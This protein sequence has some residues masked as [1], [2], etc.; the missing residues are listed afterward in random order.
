MKASQ[1]SHTIRAGQTSFWSLPREL[2]DQIYLE[3]LSDVEPAPD[4]KVCKENRGKWFPIRSN[5][6]G[7][8]TAVKHV[9][10]Q[11]P[12]TWRWS[13]SGEVQALP[14]IA[15]IVDEARETILRSRVHLD[16]CGD[17]HRSEDSAVRKWGR[18]LGEADVNSIQRLYVTWHVEAVFEQLS[19]AMKAQGLRLVCTGAWPDVPGPHFRINLE[20]N[21]QCITIRSRGELSNFNKRAFVT[22]YRWLEEQKPLRRSGKEFDGRDLLSIAARIPEMLLAQFH[23]REDEILEV[24]GYDPTSRGLQSMVMQLADEYP[25][26]VAALAIEDETVVLVEGDTNHPPVCGS[27][28]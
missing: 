20:K 17:N 23:I 5:S 15:Q 1:N 26:F 18:Q 10:M 14:P 4:L 3:T 24:R 19:G 21:R 8:W 11:D 7:L 9:R 16:L 27:L 2:R 6:S 25:Y 28:D 12:D 13:H 22:T